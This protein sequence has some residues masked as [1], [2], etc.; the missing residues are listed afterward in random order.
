MIDN[1]HFSLD[2]LPHKLKVHDSPTSNDDIRYLAR[3]YLHS[4]RTLSVTD[5]EITD[6]GALVHVSPHLRTLHFDSNALV[7]FF[8]DAFWQQLCSHYSNL[9]SLRLGSY[10]ERFNGSIFRLDSFA[11]CMRTTQTLSHLSLRYNIFE[12]E[13]FSLLCS[14]LAQNRSIQKLD[15]TGCT[16]HCP[17]IA[18]LLLANST[19]QS[20][21]LSNCGLDDVRFE[22]IQGALAKNTTLSSIDLLDNKRLMQLH[23]LVAHNT[24]LKKIKA[25][26]P[27]RLNRFLFLLAMRDFNTTLVRFYTNDPRLQAHLERNENNA[28]RRAMTLNMWCWARL[29][30]EDRQHVRLC[31]STIAEK[32][33]H[34][35]THMKYPLLTNGA[36][37]APLLSNK[38]PRPY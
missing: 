1:E 11:Q 16:L 32:N 9:T 22:P 35:F 3:R 26:L 18:S 2:R 27:R 6:I 10:S 20:L 34:L 33:T 4:V 5:T 31:Y 29:H 15:F 8:F 12:D 28:P 30:P 14:E 7:P 36:S 13:D 37:T 19:L 21:S 25:T 24:G 23:K 38:R 17:A